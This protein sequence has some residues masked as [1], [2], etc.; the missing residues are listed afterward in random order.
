MVRAL[1]RPVIFPSKSRVSG[2]PIPAELLDTPVEITGAAQNG[3]W[4]ASGWM[5]NTAKLKMDEVSTE[6]PKVGER[7]HKD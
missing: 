4:A 6:N 1:L 3:P 5:G 7:V 2:K